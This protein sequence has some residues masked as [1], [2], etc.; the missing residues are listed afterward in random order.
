LLIGKKIELKPLTPDGYTLAAKWFSDSSY[1]GNFY[2]IFPETNETIHELVESCNK[3]GGG[4]YFIWDRD[5]NEPVGA[6]GYF[7]PF[8]FSPAF[9]G[10]EIW[11]QVHQDHRGK[12]VAT[13]AASLLINH[14]FNAGRPPVNRIQATVVL[15]N[16][17]SRKVLEHSGMK[18]EGI[19]RARLRRSFKNIIE[20]SVTRRK[21]G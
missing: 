1:M 15:G 19:M 11:Y 20:V 7:N 18:E 16:E 17:A 4:A 21:H 10:F 5:K 13:Q 12:R 2:N 3:T 9:S 14:L 8:T 6:I